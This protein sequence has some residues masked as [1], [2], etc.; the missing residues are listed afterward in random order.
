MTIEQEIAALR[1]ENA[2]LKAAPHTAGRVTV[3]ISADGRKVSVYGINS[4]FPVTFYKSQW[5]RL[6][7][8]QDA[9]KALLPQLPDKEVDGSAIVAIRQAG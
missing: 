5:E 2:Q 4:R 1:L 6:F 7:Q 3:K 8:V 9:V